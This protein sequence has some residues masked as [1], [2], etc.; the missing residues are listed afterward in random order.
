ME[1]LGEIKFE[2]IFLYPKSN[3]FIQMSNLK[4]IEKAGF[5]TGA[6]WDLNSKQKNLRP[7]IVHDPILM[8]MD[9]SSKI[10]KNWV[11]FN[12]ITII[13]SKVLMIESYDL[14]S[15][16]F[17]NTHPVHVGVPQKQHG[18]FKDN[19]LGKNNTL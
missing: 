14:S 10:T 7:N 8:Y 16:V 18:P 3:S 11:Y 12:I 15:I 13:F 6:V 4:K 9:K 2:S 19:I 17:M 5:Y 1:T